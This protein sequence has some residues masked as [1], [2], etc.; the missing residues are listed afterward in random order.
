MEKRMKKQKDLELETQSK[1]YEKV[2]EDLKRGHK[3][4][5]AYIE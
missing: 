1:K 5:K 3:E 2:I 4:D